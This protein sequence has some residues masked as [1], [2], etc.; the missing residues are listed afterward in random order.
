MKVSNITI[1]LLAGTTLFLT[2]CSNTNSSSGSSSSSSL[3]TSK[4]STKI[5]QDNL[6]PQQTVSLVTAYAGNK[7]G[8]HWATVAKNA[9]KD[10]LQVDLYS[11]DHYQLSDKGQGVAYNVRAGN[12]TSDLIYTVNGND[13]TIFERAQANQPA[14]K[15]ISV[16]RSAMVKYINANGQG[17]LVNQLAQSAQVND[18]RTSNDSTTSNSSASTANSQTGKYGNEGAVTVPSGL[19]GTW[20]SADGGNEDSITFGQNTLQTSDGTTKLYKQS[21]EFLNNSDNSSNQQIANATEDWGRTTIFN[22]NGMQWLN[23]QGWLQGAGDGSYFAA[24][25]ETI[26]GKQVK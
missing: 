7:F 11:A 25:T 26:N 19:R 1:V 12:K 9:Q 15:L 20:Y 14:K 2:G 24:H 8:D 18:K 13:V 16:S 22:H 5:S 10:G 17:K 23:V 4:S 21:K 6:T 3:L